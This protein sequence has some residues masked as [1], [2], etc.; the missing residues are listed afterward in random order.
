MEHRIFKMIGG[1]ADGSL[2]Q[3]YD[4]KYPDGT[5]GWDEVPVDVY[6]RYVRPDNVN[7]WLTPKTKPN[8]NGTNVPYMI[9][10]PSSLQEVE[11]NEPTPSPNEEP[12]HR[13]SLTQTT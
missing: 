8:I 7:P 3:L 9:W 1:P 2:W 4:A 6:G 12:P 10:E 5:N 13:V 11:S